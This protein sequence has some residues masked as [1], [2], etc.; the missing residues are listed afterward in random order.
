MSGMGDVSAL[1]K[2]QAK[3]TTKWAGNARNLRNQ[4]TAG[5][6]SGQGFWYFSAKNWRCPFEG[7][8]RLC[9]PY[10]NASFHSNKNSFTNERMSLLNESFFYICI[11]SWRWKS[12]IGYRLSVIAYSYSILAVSVGN[13]SSSLSPLSEL[14]ILADLR[15]EHVRLIPISAFIDV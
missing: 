10:C 9:L 12:I 13:V 4:S 3:S 8:C 5:M 7:G 14:T 15:Q 2:S 6:L 1:L 11:K